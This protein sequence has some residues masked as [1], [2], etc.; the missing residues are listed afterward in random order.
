MISKTKYA[1]NKALINRAVDDLPNVD[2]KLTLNIPTGRFFYDPWVIKDEFKGTIWEELLSAINESLG[3]A[4][5]IKLAPGTCY[6]G[7]ADIDDRWHLSLDD[8]HSYL[9][10][11]D[12]KQL[13]KTEPDGTWY[14]MDTSP[15]HS[16]VN[17]GNGDRYQLVVR[18]LLKHTNLVD[19]VNVK[20]KL[21]K[22][23][24]RSRCIFDQYFST[25]LNKAAKQSKIDDFELTGETGVSF[26]VD[27]RYLNEL[28]ELALKTDGMFEV[29]NEF[30]R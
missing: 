19:P 27:R 26:L 28:H 2:F 8:S 12:N 7:H 13:H 25:W 3:E 21:V 5:I 11:I 29:D 16:A 20:I 9:V 22:P 15:I 17:F 14:T 18:Q 10:D 1:V 6:F 23:T 4:R 30:S 24:A